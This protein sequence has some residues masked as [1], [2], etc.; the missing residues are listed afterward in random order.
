MSKYR[1]RED[2]KCSGDSIYCIE[3]LYTHWLFSDEWR[4]LFQP[5][6]GF[7]AYTKYLF[8]TKEEAEETLKEYLGRHL[9]ET[10]YHEA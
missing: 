2:V 9:K 4:I 3:Y 8:S 6:E 10:I 1:I 5:P 7:M